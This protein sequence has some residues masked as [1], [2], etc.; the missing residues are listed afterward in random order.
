M[1]NRV[2]YG[3]DILKDAKSS[4]VK[5]LFI[6]WKTLAQ[7]KNLTLSDFLEAGSKHLE[8]CVVLLILGD[9]Y[10]FVYQGAE[11]RE[12]IGADIG[13]KFISEIDTRVARDMRKVYDQVRETG[14][15]V[16]LIFA[17]ESA[18]FAIGWERLIIP[19]VIGGEVRMLLTYS[20]PL[21]TANDVHRYLFDSSPHMLIVALPISNYENEIVDADIISI[22]P[23]AV[24]FFRTE[25]FSER[26]IALRGLGPWFDQ[27]A[28]WRILTGATETGHR[29][30]VLDGDGGERG[31]R[32]IVVKLDYLLL[33]RI[34][35][36]DAPERFNVD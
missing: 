4:T 26:P 27:D 10:S 6:R 9:D 16:R 12:A 8:R 3:D 30:H 33:F 29:E 17:S 2:S 15:P 7:L 36:L 23:A 34:F 11:Y 24:H 25:R 14:M 1:L 21:N 19:I 35:P 28:I 22:N 20:E 13:G 32:C 31:Y 18:T 5:A